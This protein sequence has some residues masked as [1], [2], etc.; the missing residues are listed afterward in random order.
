MS[1]LEY[2]IDQGGQDHIVDD[3]YVV[4]QLKGMGQPVSGVSADGSMV[5]FQDQ[6]GKP[7]EVKMNDVL[8]GLG[9]TVKAA[10]PV[11]AD[12]STVESMLS[13]MIN[14]MPEDDDMRKSYIEAKLRRRGIDSP[15]VVGKGNVWHVFNP[16]TNQWAQLTEEPGANMSGLAAGALAAPHMVGA[17]LGG[18]A[19]LAAGIPGG[20]PGSIALAALGG[21]AGG[22]AGSALTHAGMA[23]LDP[24]YLEATKGHG[25][26]IGSDIITKGAL[27]AAGEGLGAPFMR[28]LPINKVAQV[29]GDALKGA[30][31]LASA[32]AKKIAGSELGTTLTADM[33]APSP[34]SAMT[35]GGQLAMLPKEA[36]EFAAKVPGRLSESPMARQFMSEESAAKM[37]AMSKD[38]LA[39]GSNAKDILGQIG[40]KRAA[41]AKYAADA[42]WATEEQAARDAA[43]QMAGQFGITNPD[44]VEALATAAGGDLRSQMIGKMRMNS[45]SPRL[46]KAGE[47]IDKLY[48]AGKGVSELGIGLTRAGLRGIQGLGKAAE[49]AGQ[50]LSAAGPVMQYGAI[51]AA[52]RY[53]V[54]PAGKHWWEDEHRRP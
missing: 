19:G 5:T 40:S 13:G 21:G 47:T 38:L 26:Q 11:T 37:A 31:S 30:G 34:I 46:E 18:A 45:S 52:M 43:R 14:A 8:K 36:I 17:A 7:Y 15:N 9:M 12:N 22:A 29:A 25:N 50:G 54:M 32:G 6:A 49:F 24:A 4:Q 33:L 10:M 53:G 2:T 42:G 27:D 23:A 48:G 20:L 41:T 51:P 3:D 1:S 44:E 28:M 39:K 16:N 35:G